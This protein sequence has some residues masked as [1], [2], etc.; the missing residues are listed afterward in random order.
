[1]VVVDVDWSLF[2]FVWCCVVLLCFC[3]VCS[4]GCCCFF[5]VACALLV[6]S[7]LVACMDRIGLMGQYLARVGMA[8]GVLCTTA[9]Q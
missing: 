2:F 7:L 1:M 8:D 6:T 5:N 4:G 3:V 9:C